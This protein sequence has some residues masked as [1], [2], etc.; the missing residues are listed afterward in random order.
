MAIVERVA[1]WQETQTIFLESFKNSNIEIVWGIGDPLTRAILAQCILLHC[2]LISFN[3]TRLENKIFNTIDKY[4]HTKGYVRERAYTHILTH[5]AIAIAHQRY[6]SHDF[7]LIADTL[8]SKTTKKKRPLRFEYVQISTRIPVK[9]PA[10]V[11]LSIPKQGKVSPDSIQGRVITLFMSSILVF[12]N[13]HKNSVFIGC[14][15]CHEK[16]KDFSKAKHLTPHDL[17]KPKSIPK[18]SSSFVNIFFHWQSLHS[19]SFLGSEVQTNICMTFSSYEEDS[20]L[21]EETCQVYGEYFRHS[22]CS[23]FEN[24]ILFYKDFLQISPKHSLMVEHSWKIFP[25]VQNQTD[26]SFQV[27]FPNIKYFD[28]NLKAYLTPVNVDIWLYF[29]V[30]LIGISIWFVWIENQ[31]IVVVMILQFSILLEQSIQQLQAMGARGNSVLTAWIYCSIFLRFCYT[32]S[33]YSLMTAEEVTNDYPHNMEQLFNRPDFDLVLTDSFFSTI[34]WTFVGNDEYTP[35]G[36]ERF[37]VKVVQK[38]YFVEG[39]LASTTILNLM[40]GDAVKIWYFPEK[41]STRIAFLDV[42]S[43]K[44]ATEI[45]QKFVL[46]YE[47]TYDKNWGA[48]VP[49]T[50]V[51]KLHR[52]LLRESRIFSSN[53][54]WS[55]RSP[56]FVTIRFSKFIGSLV[57]SGLYDLF[58]VRFKKLSRLKL[59]KEDAKKFNRVRY[60]WFS[61]VFLANENN[62][63]LL[64]TTP[65]ATKLSNFAVVLL[66]AVIIRAGR[67]NYGTLENCGFPVIEPTLCLGSEPNYH[68]TVQHLVDIERYKKY[69]PIWG[70]YVG[71]HPHVFVADPDLIRQIFVKDFASHFE[72]RQDYEFGTELM[73][74]SVEFQKYE[75]WRTLRNFLSP[76]FST[77]KLKHMSEVIANCAEEFANDLKSECDEGGRVK[78]HGRDRFSTCL[79]DMFAQTTLGIRMEDSKNINNKFAQAFRALMN[80]EGEYNWIYSLSLSYPILSK[81][82]PLFTEV[83]GMLDSTFR[84]IIKQRIAS[85]S[86]SSKDF[87]DLLCDLWKRV[88]AG[89]YK[90]LGFTETTVLAQCVLF[91]LGGYETSATT[92]SHVLYIM[93]YHPEVQDKM[94]KELENALKNSKGGS[95]DHELISESNI[96][97]ITACIN[98]T[99]RIYPSVYRPE[100]ICGKDWSHNGISIKKG[101]VVMI[102]TWA[103]N[104]NPKFYPDEPDKF[105]PERFLQENKGNIEPYA[106]TSF[107]FGPRNCIGMRFAYE[108]MKLFICHIVKNF[109]VELRSDTVLDYKCG[110]PIVVSLQ[111]LYL[112]LVARQT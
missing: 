106:F 2:I 37:Y 100:R 44:T 57:H 49:F 48:L 8:S 102:P 12:V 111:P 17:V 93:A 28:A 85:G 58:I 39:D 71:R 83:T 66:A 86:S 52:V 26:I 35:E 41:N 78:L 62:D 108:S 64:S 25:A 6:S 22:N 31:N 11:L 13:L 1:L 56:S 60:S 99:L 10:A 45:F 88:E 40:N 18:S 82:A 90:E 67:V 112:D 46:M 20:I 19:H 61:Y 73:N 3:T 79:I 42:Y 54:F 109:R 70:S 95:I 84:T 97:F 91:F 33:L 63:D 75:E 98:E 51:T 21:H 55:E 68:K 16:F 43:K 92:L 38:A 4:I 47:T 96:P 9:L 53:V 32:W 94:E 36:L 110:V 27:L 87:L 7:I 29:G 81:F 107:G 15:S 34:Y 24:C 50:G 30:A 72:N 101:T 59:L 69:G 89:E 14:F 80:E 76:L 23:N 105:K 103:A 74:Q 77:S 5:N 104:R 65:E